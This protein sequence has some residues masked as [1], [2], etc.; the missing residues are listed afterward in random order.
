MW[1][2]DEQELDPNLQRAEE[3]LKK[4]KYKEAIPLLLEPL[5]GDDPWIFDTCREM[6]RMLPNDMALAYLLVA[7]KRGK[8]QVKKL[9]APDCFEDG[10]KY[11]APDFWG[12]LDTRPYMRVLCRI[13]KIYIEEK[14]WSD[15]ADVITEMLRLCSSD[16]Q[17]IRYWF[18]AVLIHAGRTADALYF[19]QSWLEANRN[20]TPKGKPLKFAPPRLTPMS[21]KLLKRVGEWVNVQFVHSAALAT[22]MLDGDSELARQYLHLAVQYPAVL[23]K[24]LGKFRERT[25]GDTNPYRTSDG[26]ADGRDHLWLAQ[27]LWMQVPV[28]NWANNDL[29]VKEH[30]LRLCGAPTCRKKEQH[31]GQ[32]NKCAGCKDVSLLNGIVARNAKKN[33]GWLTG[34]AAK[35]SNSKRRT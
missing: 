22:F 10:C 1:S 31:V 27:D 15:A 9:V 7:E 19:T 24:V 17:G 6:S 20:G 11:G 5:K 35:K 33:I 16:N 26:R 2:E 13:A 28:W 30:A 34:L 3:L 14:R 29:V 8:E 23:I 25:V 21:S 32:W 18:P 12:I 4:K